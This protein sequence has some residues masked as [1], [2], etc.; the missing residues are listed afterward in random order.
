[1]SSNGLTEDLAATAPIANMPPA[2]PSCRQRLLLPDILKTIPETPAS[3]KSHHLASWKGQRKDYLVALTGK[4]GPIVPVMFRWNQRH[5]PNGLRYNRLQSTIRSIPGKDFKTVLTESFR[6]GAP[7]DYADIRDIAL[8][9]HLDDQ[10][11]G[12]MLAIDSPWMQAFLG[13][14]RDAFSR[15]SNDVEWLDTDEA[16]RLIDEYTGK[17]K[18]TGMKRKPKDDGDDDNEDNDNDNYNSGSAHGIPCSSASFVDSDPAS[19]DEMSVAMSAS[20]R[21]KTDSVLTVAPTTVSG[22]RYVILPLFVTAEDYRRDCAENYTP[23]K[24]RY[25]PPFAATNEEE[26]GLN[27]SLITRLVSQDENLGLY[28]V[29]DLRQ[30]AGLAESYAEKPFTKNFY[31]RREK[32]IQL[33]RLFSKVL[34]SY[35][36]GDRGE[37]SATANAAIFPWDEYPPDCREHIKSHSDIGTWDRTSEIIVGDRIKV[38]LHKSSGA[39]VQIDDKFLRSLTNAS[40]VKTISPAELQTLEKLS[41]HTAARG[42]YS[43]PNVDARAIVERYNIPTDKLA[44]CAAVANALLAQ[45]AM[46]EAREPLEYRHVFWLVELSA[47]INRG[48]EKTA[49]LHK[50]AEQTVNAQAVS[51]LSWALG[52]IERAISGSEDGAAF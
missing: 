29:R 28:D 6:L 12:T 32:E 5:R 49:H 8:K 1:M 40:L 26:I 47:A 4:G 3:L 7:N 48:Y 25:L 9:L 43:G 50:T 24:R 14:Q 18:T 39:E 13:W 2:T 19:S 46:V 11:R 38:L 22:S 45:Y 17:A 10:N 20:T 33:L 21:K 41:T 30:Y 34:R 16:K 23:G 35:V 37:H 15:R 42:I 44:G 52:W 51:A 36:E 27:M 31:D